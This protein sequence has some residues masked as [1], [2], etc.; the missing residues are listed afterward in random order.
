[1]PPFVDAETADL[2][3]AHLQGMS[4]HLSGV[5]APEVQAEWDRDCAQLV[6]LLFVEL[7]AR[8]RERVAPWALAG[9]EELV[10][11]EK[12]DKAG[13]FKVMAQTEMFTVEEMLQALVQRVQLAAA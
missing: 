13:I 12:L 11:I 6:D 1:M 4:R 2:L 3:L 7:D 10:P 9:S 8:V 5:V